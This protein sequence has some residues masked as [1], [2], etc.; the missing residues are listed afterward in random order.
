MELT[1][2]ETCNLQH[3]KSKVH[4]VTWREGREGK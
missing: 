1:F 4:P 2:L 3:C